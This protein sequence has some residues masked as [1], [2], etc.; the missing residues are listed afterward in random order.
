MTNPKPQ[1]YAQAQ[2]MSYAEDGGPTVLGEHYANPY[3]PENMQAAKETLA[4]EGIISPVSFSV[5][6]THYYVKFSPRSMDE[7]TSL[8]RNEDLTLSDIPLDYEVKK[9]GN[10]YREPGLP[11]DVP[12]PQYASVSKDFSFNPDIPYQILSA[13]YIPEEE[14]NLTENPDNG[15]GGRDY[16]VKLL[17]KA[18]VLKH[19][20][21][22]I[23]L[24]DPTQWEIGP[25][26]PTG[27]IKIYDSRLGQN[28]ALEGVKVSGNRWFTTYWGTTNAT[29]QYTLNG[30]FIR[31]A[32]Y[33]IHLQRADFS[34]ADY[35]LWPFMALSKIVRYNQNGTHWNYTIAPGYENMQGHMFRAAYR[36]YYKDIDGLTRP[37][38]SNYTQVLVAKNA[39]KDWSG[40]N[41]IALPILKVARFSSSGTEY[42]SDEI[43]ST[44]IHELAHTA[45]VKTMSLGSVSYAIMSSLI[46]ESWP[47]AVEWYLT[48][49]EYK[50]L[51]ISNYGEHD[52]NPSNPPQYPNTYAY[53]YWSNGTSSDYTSLFIN[54]IDNFNENGHS[55]Q[56]WGIGTVNDQVSGYSPANIEDEILSGSY[57]LSSLS[58]ELKAHKP[59]G[60]TNAQIDQLLNSY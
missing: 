24:D 6:T 37:T 53:Q 7:L 5:A 58:T 48:G 57:G 38:F 25:I 60:V 14:P 2:N 50:G 1:Q 54:L 12:T 26:P 41:Y 34:I 16:A 19:V 45:H 18:F 27:T 47:C 21:F 11:D 23:P 32:D 31:D 17:G 28:I 22:D 10:W 52:Y 44:T 33:T 56:G 49:K 3:T 40:I 29:G 20:P 4:Q 39:A 59:A 55:F 8:M 42:G 43:F 35:T 13:L 51:G 30:A 15:V 9:V 36:Y 46:R